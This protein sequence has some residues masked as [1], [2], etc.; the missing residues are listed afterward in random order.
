MLHYDLAHSGLTLPR[1]PVPFTEAASENPSAGKEF[2]AGQ[3]GID[4]WSE[5]GHYRKGRG[6]VELTWRAGDASHPSFTVVESVRVSKSC[7]Q[8]PLDP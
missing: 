3:A 7:I 6:K 8:I 4:M 1:D 5:P 2:R